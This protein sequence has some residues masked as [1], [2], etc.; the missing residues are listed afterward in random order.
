MI[1]NYIALDLGAESGRAVVGRFDGDRL[2]LEEAHRF[3]NGPV[4]ILDSLHWDVLYLFEQ[5]KEG[6][7]RSAARVDGRVA[8]IGLDTWAVDFGLLGPDD[9]LLGNPYHYRDSRTEGLVEEASRFLSPQELFAQTGFPPIQISSLYQLLSM[10]WTDS[11]VLKVAHR[12]LLMPDLFNFWLTGRKASEFTIVPNTQCYNPTKREW[13]WDLLGKVGIPTRL[14]GE[15]VPP[16]TVLGHLLSPVA[17]DTGLNEALDVAPACHDSAAAVVAVP[18]REQDY[19]FI[20]SGTWSV[21][22]TEVSSPVLTPEALA[23]YLA[24]EGGVFGTFRFTSNIMGLWLVQECRRTWAQAREDYSY[25]D[26]MQMAARGRPFSCLV[27]PNDVR[28]LAPGD[29][30]DRIRTFCAETDQP[31]PQ[32]KADVL[33]CILESLAL[34]YRRGIEDIEEMLGRR[35]KI[36][37][38][39]GGGSRNELLCQFTADATGRPVLAGP[40]EAT[41]SGNLLM[42][43]LALG[44]LS[45]LEEARELIRASFNL[46]LCEPGPTAAWDEAYQRFL[47]YSADEF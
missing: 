4:R 1:R 26:L 3:P 14:F 31:I 6:L 40:G 36:I 16:G 21:L 19:I 11:P 15:I 44:D 9:L 28:F 5:I 24:N 37:H 42:Q 17:A 47:S 25:V 2:R 13:A 43:A 39:V 8:S 12:F 29:M 23:R 7:R 38:I 32:S 33:R 45:S 41:A 22:G 18:T 30:P 34:R 35:M 46:T 20:S 10:V 27:N